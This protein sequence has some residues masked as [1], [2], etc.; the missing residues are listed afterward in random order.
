MGDGDSQNQGFFSAPFDFMKCERQAT[1]FFRRL[2][3]AIF[4]AAEPLLQGGHA[5]PSSVIFCFEIGMLL[6]KCIFSRSLPFLWTLIFRLA[7]NTWQ[8]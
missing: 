1:I 2:C 5:T 3:L 7:R 8:R 6:A 4:D